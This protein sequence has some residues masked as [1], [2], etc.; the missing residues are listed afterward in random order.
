MLNVFFTSITN[1]KY[2]PVE[3]FLTVLYSFDEDEVL[4]TITYEY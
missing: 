4:S 3:V 1:L 2:I